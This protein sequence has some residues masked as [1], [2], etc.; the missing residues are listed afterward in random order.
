MK[1]QPDTR[2]VSTVRCAG[3]GATTTLPENVTAHDC[4]YCGAPIVAEKIRQRLIKPAS[5]L[6]FAID[7]KRAMGSFGEWLAT[8]W[9]APNDLKKYAEADG[10]LVGLYVPYWTFDARTI[11][12]YRGQRGDTYTVT[13]G[14][15]KNRRTETRIRWTS[16][17]GTIYRNFNDVLVLA[18]RSLPQDYAEKLE[19]WDLPNLTPY[20]DE[21]LSGF[22]AES[23]SVELVEGFGRAKQRMEETIIRLI[24]DDIGGDRQRIDAMRTQHNNVTFKHVLLPVWMSAYRYRGRLF[25]ILV[26]ARTAEVQGERPY[27]ALKIAFAVALGLLILGVIIWFI[28]THAE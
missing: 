19:P 9:F 11:T 17:S 20:A 15:G 22:R 12:F 7:Q 24:K 2:D 4:P 26:N 5:L 27:S 10:K 16:V 21:Y 8:R 6:P 23:Y 18:S 25:R 13:V 3:C 14:T 1:E 28:V